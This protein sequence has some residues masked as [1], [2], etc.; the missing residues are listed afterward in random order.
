LTGAFL[1]GTLDL[2]KFSPQI[3]Q[4]FSK[5]SPVIGQ[6]K[7]KLPGTAKDVVKAPTAHHVDVKN[8]I[9]ETPA[10][11]LDPAV[12]VVKIIEDPVKVRQ[13]KHAVRMIVLRRK[14]MK[15]HK[16]KRLWQRMH[17][18][19]RAARVRREKKKELTFRYMLID[20]IAVARK[21]DAEKYVSDYLTDYHTP[22][23][24]KTY[25]G[26]RKPAWLIKEILE[27]DILDEKE[28]A[29][30]GKSLTTKEMLVLPGETV[31][32]FIQRTSSK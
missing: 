28:K 3:D 24:P 14:M 13:K 20:K 8:F 16:L 21:F 31:Q 15:N 17:L 19:F 30:E 2:N 6:V 25:K 4:N 10:E 7:I 23:L 22:L 12:G 27:Q 9:V 5:F 32:Q 18:K 1:S 26:S 11:I 29:M